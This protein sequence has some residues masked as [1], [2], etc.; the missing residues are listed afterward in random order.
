[1]DTLEPVKKNMNR[2]TKDTSGEQKFIFKL[3]TDFSQSA[4]KLK[5]KY[6]QSTKSPGFHQIPVLPRPKLPL[7]FILKNYQ[8]CEQII[9]NYAVK[10]FRKK[11]SLVCW[12]SSLFKRRVPNSTN[13]EN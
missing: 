5:Q 9:K 2:T 3:H 1:M 7:Q 6:N 8:I 13:F 11:E 4:F 10:V 12:E